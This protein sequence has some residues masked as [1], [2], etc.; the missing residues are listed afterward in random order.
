MKRCGV[1]Q[2]CSSRAR[3]TKPLAPQYA[4]AADALAREQKALDAHIAGRRLDPARVAARDRALDE[5]VNAA[6]EPPEPGEP[7]A[8]G[9]ACCCLKRWRIAGCD[10]AA[11]V[12]KAAMCKG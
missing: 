7:G 9:R 2:T 6:T 4:A 10:A 12:A 3:Y 8:R 1:A 5:L 11:A